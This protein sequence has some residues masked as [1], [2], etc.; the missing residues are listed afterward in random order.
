MHNKSFID[1]FNL[2]L[3]LLHNFNK[4]RLIFQD[5]RRYLMFFVILAYLYGIGCRANA[6]GSRQA[7]IH[8][9]VELFIQ[10]LLS[11]LMIKNNKKQQN[12]NKL[13]HY[14]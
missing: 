2:V 13:I 5:R 4:D 8:E 14:L 10:S 11:G 12:N 6:M 9:A 7:A 1:L 3:N